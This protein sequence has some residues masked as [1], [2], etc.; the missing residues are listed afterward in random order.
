MATTAH[1]DDAVYNGDGIDVYPLESA[2]IQMVAEVITV[3]D[4]GGRDRFEVDVDMTFKNHGAQTTVQMG[5]PILTDWVDGE[6]IEF[7][8]HLRTWVNGKEVEIIKKRGV[9]NPL[10][11]VPDPSDAVYTYPVTFGQNET[12][13]IKH[14][15]AVGG[16]FYSEG[17]WRF[18][19]IL[20]TG[21]LWKDVIEK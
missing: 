14:Q 10:G 20:R 8:P 16:T 13:K 17:S 21:A 12:I 1:A 3:P 7:D 15:Y 11:K 4:K 19:Y 6:R 9:P 5:F 18:V 2:D